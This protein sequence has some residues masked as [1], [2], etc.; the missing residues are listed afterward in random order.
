MKPIPGL[1]RLFRLAAGRSTASDDVAEE[2]QLH[3]DL[4][5]EELVA[6]GLNPEQA[7]A[8]ALRLF[9]NLSV[10]KQTVTAI[11]RERERAVRRSEWFDS[12]LGD[13]RHAMRGLR[14]SPGFAIGTA[15][16]LGL[17]IGLNAAI[18]SVFDGVILQ[19]LPFA[20]PERLVR[21]W[22]TQSE[23]GL[24]LF[25][26]SIADFEDW[27]SQSTS[28]EQLAA[29][30]RQQDLTL[31]GNADP[32][33]IQGAR[34][35]A[36]LFTLLGVKPA[37]GR[38]FSAAEDRPGAPE[39]P[40]VISHAAWRN[41]LG[42]DSGALGRVLT[43]NGEPWT[44]IG[45][46]PR[47]FFIP[48]NPAEVWMPLG[49]GNQTTDRGRRFLRVLGRLKPGV[50]IDAVRAELL[51]IARRLEGQY[52]ATNTDWTVTAL[53][54]TEA[55]NGE[56]FTSAVKILLGAVAL[57]LLI[58][59]VNVATMVLGR[60]SARARELAVRAAL[61]AGAGR[62]GRFLLAEG[63]LL[64]AIGGAFGV[65]LAAALVR[66]LHALEPPNLPRLEQVSVNGSVVALAALLSIGS[67]LLFGLVP[68][69]RAARAPLA[70]SL[71]EGG[72]GVAGGRSRQRTQRILVVAE[73]TLAVLLL[74]GAGLLIQSLIRLQR[75]E[76]GFESR[77]I[78]AVRLAL[79]RAQYPG[80]RQ[81]AE[82]YTQLLER[83]RA[84]PGVRAAAAV[85]VVPLSGPNTGN[86]FAVEG[87]PVPNPESTPDADVRAAT[88][89]YFRLMTIPLLAGRDFTEQDD[90][91]SGLVAVIS[92]TAARR[93]WPD[94][95]PLGARIRIG[96]VE[97]GP[98]AEVV[99]VV[100]DVRHLSLESPE[101]RPMIYFPLRSTGTPS[102]TVVLAGPGD[103]ATL[104][105]AF[106]REVNALDPGLPLGSVRAMDD[107]VADEFTQRRFN[108]IVLGLFALAALV[109]A[110]I[111]LYGVM[112][113]AVSQRTHE[114]GV[115]LA[116]GAQRSQVVRM[117]LG[118]S[119]R[120]VGGGVVLG[121]GGAVLLNG[122]LSTMLFEVKPNDPLS[123][124]GA[125]ALL[126][127]I[128]LLGSF[129]PARRAAR[130]DPLVALREG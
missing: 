42:A 109:L 34:I 6:E 106:R 98:L 2:L 59:C 47:D 75:V 43:L 35:S 38:L 4:R 92:A 1:R 58:A 77:D 27:R 91:T 22:S 18:F 76:L 103:P 112:A 20:E 7:R 90:S 50:S 14:R 95:S 40:L 80:V 15:L 13:F 87:R 97:R 17:G 28:F 72:R 56:Q 10:I 96:N 45:V 19:P 53:S 31:T 79:P 104:T 60:N 93:Y 114:L 49:A 100:G 122:M 66:L 111:G 12:L 127:G 119:L 33:Q 41:R 84:L 94:Q 24:R 105:G 86:I 89:G 115:R 82:F 51:T 39:R 54:L 118:E 65:A 61:G 32:V 117:V 99:G 9:G 25:S 83:T 126:V 57:V 107:V 101:H 85:S 16:T 108:V 123:L 116:L 121:L 124:I 88:P 11:D 128:A 46:M 120:L 55:V 5:A 63:L 125:T 113:Y 3:V 30:D 64:G 73:M 81:P 74:S 26:V 23:R 102:M 70:E 52:P 68:L 48:G 130:V 29:F 8:E 67:G 36:N 78:L 44:V 129:L 37:L 62:L 71:R 69:R 110:G 21:I